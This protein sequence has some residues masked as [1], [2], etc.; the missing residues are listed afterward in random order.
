[1]RKHLRSQQHQQRPAPVPPVPPVPPQGTSV[2]EAVVGNSNGVD[3]SCGNDGNDAENDAADNDA[4]GNDAAGKGDE[5]EAQD[6]VVSI[7]NE[8][9]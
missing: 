2:S 8:D 5:D 4:A 6:I 9:T 7:I 3:S 1:M